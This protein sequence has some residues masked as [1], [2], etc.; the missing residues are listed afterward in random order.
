MNNKII[1][2]TAKNEILRLTNQ[3][4]EIVGSQNKYAR[5]KGISEATMSN[6]V[7]KKWSVIS[8]EMWRKLAAAC[9]YT[10]KEWHLAEIAAFR[11][12][13]TLIQDAQEN[14]NVYA[15]TANAGGG[16]SSTCKY[17][18]NNIPN[19]FWLECDEFWNKKQFLSELLQAMGRNSDGMTAYEMMVELKRH[20]TKLNN[21]V[22]I[23]DEVD[24]LK[25]EVLYFF[26]SLY[27]RLQ[28]Q[29]GIILCATDFLEKRIIKGL[30]LNRKGYQEIY[31]RLG[32]KFIELT[33]VSRVDVHLIC[34]A[35]G[36]EDKKTITSIYNDSDDDLR[37]VK[38]LVHKYKVLSHE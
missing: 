24:K 38:K 14:A 23:L 12:M 1:T 20:T 7:Q 37:R 34:R 16:K 5:S 21:P 28:D 3:Q 29:C 11:E 27:N 35:N 36:I 26:I 17:Y 15:V 18:S 33:P 19:A 8:E 10:D 4:I 6:F 25:D 13:T 30:R 9:S 32:R 2:N 22:I 31:S